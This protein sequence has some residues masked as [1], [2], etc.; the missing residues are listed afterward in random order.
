MRSI[1]DSGSLTDFGLDY[2]KN[3]IRLTLLFSLVCSFFSE[4]LPTEKSTLKQSLENKLVREVKSLQ[5]RHRIVSLSFSFFHGDDHKFDYATGYADLNGRKKATPDHIYTIAS[6]T[7]SITAMTLIDL[8]NQ[9][10][11][12]LGDSVHKIIEGFPPNVT[13]LDLLNHTSGF[14]REKENENF[15]AGS[16]YRDVVEH[17]PVKFNLKIHRYANYNYAVIGVIIEKI[18]KKKFSSVANNYYHSL[19]RDSLYFSNHKKKKRD[20]KFVLNYVK[21]GRRRYLHKTVDFGLWEPAAFAQTTA[22][23]LATFMRQHM[24]PQFIEY[25]KEHAVTIKTRKRRGNRIVK[26]CY[27]L[28]FRLRYINGKLKYI[29]HNG[30]LYGV[31]STMYYFPE[32]D[33]GFVVLANMSD[34]PNETLSLSGFYAKVEQILDAEFNKKVSLYTANYGFTAGLIHYEEIQSKGELKE[35][36]INRYAK[37]Y[38][39][40]NKVKEALNLYQLGNYVFPESGATYRKLAK[41]YILNGQEELAEETLIQGLMVEPNMKTSLYMLKSLE[42]KGTY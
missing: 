3:M 10:Y 9:N 21:K 35:Y 16:S 30:F 29:Y 26:D 11:L 15:L 23:G 27:G 32:K 33:A 25:M 18:M 28:G 36:L 17:L 42:T 6:I 34:Y 19:T 14:L 39:K 1:Y 4:V 8:V 13:I 24:T 5:K 12:S 41:A 31:L 7:K 22:A 2:L 20:K 40:K 38:L 37:S